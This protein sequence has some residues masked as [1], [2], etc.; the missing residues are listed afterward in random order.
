MILRYG[1]PVKIYLDN[2]KVYVSRHF[3]SILAALRIK[4][5]HHKPYQAYAKGKIEVVNRTIKYDFQK[6]AERAGMRN[7][8]QTNPDEPAFPGNELPVPIPTPVG[9]HLRCLH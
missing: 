2:G 4:Q 9:R 5:I 6:E 7:L 8:G 1:I 3:S